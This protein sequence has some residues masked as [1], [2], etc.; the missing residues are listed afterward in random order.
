[1]HENC[2]KKFE[3]SFFCYLVKLHSFYKGWGE[4]SRICGARV[5]HERVI[6]CFFNYRKNKS[7][8]EKHVTWHGARV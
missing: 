7:M 1:M 3:K 2:K 6:Y 4:I 5:K 8:H